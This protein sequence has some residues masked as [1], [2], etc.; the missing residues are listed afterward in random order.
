MSDAQQDS[1]DEDSDMK[2]RQTVKS[3]AQ[4]AVARP[5][6][7]RSAAAAKPTARKPPPRTINPTRDPFHGAYAVKLYVMTEPFLYLTN[8]LTVSVRGIQNPLEMD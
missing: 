8:R 1:D 6:A 4:R 5:P 2:T 3:V 7:R